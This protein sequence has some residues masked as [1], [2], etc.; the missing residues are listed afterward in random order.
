[1]SYLDFEI[2]FQWLHTMEDD[3]DRWD[4]LSDMEIDLLLDT[5]AG[6]LYCTCE[7]G[8]GTATVCRHI[9]FIIIHLFHTNADPNYKAPYE[10]LPKSL[11]TPGRIN[12]HF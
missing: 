2:F 4:D 7:S 9:M 8:A 5:L 3:P 11:R 10:Y 12:K 6:S 1:M